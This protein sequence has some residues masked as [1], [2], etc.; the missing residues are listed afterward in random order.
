LRSA[1]L[2]KTYGP[3]SEKPRSADAIMS[4]SERSTADVVRETI[5]RDGSIK[6]GLARGLINERALARYIQKATHE[7]YTFEALVS[8]IRRHPIHESMKARTITGKMIRKIGLKNNISVVLLRNRV[9]LQPVL[10]RFAGELDHA[11]GDTFRIITTAKVVKLEIDS[12]N[13]DDLLARVQR[14]DLLQRWDNM[15]EISVETSEEMRDTP[16]IIATLFTELAMNGVS[17]LEHSSIDEPPKT[18]GKSQQLGQYMAKYIPYDI[19]IIEEGNAT[20]AYEALQRL[21]EV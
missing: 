3:G 1:R 21:R 7:R 6:I 8:A 10:A 5:E 4:D 18:E 17:V 14:G 13:A 20:K 9:E 12:K 19:F 15:A 16:G 2:A 11:G